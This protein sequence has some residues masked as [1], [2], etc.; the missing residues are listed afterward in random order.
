MKQLKQVNHSLGLEV[1]SLKS[2]VVSLRAKKSDEASLQQSALME[3]V[4]AEHR[5]EVEQLIQGHTREIEALTSQIDLLG[6]NQHSV[7]EVGEELRAKR[8]EIKNLQDTI[9]KMKVCVP[10]YMLTLLCTTCIA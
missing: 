8:V 3:K 7:D 10:L 2:E 5:K 4:K 9:T 6:R 1:Q